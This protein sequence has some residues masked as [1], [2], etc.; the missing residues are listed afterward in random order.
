MHKWSVLVALFF[1]TSFLIVPQS[2]AAS[3]P[4][5]RISVYFSSQDR[6]L[7]EVLVALYREVQKGGYI[8]IITSSL[9]HP[10]LG[11][12][13][14]EARKRGVDVKLISDRRM[15]DTKRDE[16]AMYNLR[17]MGISIKVNQF[18]GA[19][20]LEASIVDDRYLV[21]GSYNY[22][23]TEIRS[24]LGVRVDEQ[25]LMVIPTGVD[26]LILQRYKDEFQRMWNDQKSYK[27][28][29]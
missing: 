24:P 21:V 1:I 14:A 20:Q 12:A 2:S 5:D 4:F 29:E 17:A 9:T 8:W 11:H 27:A 22:G 3:L 23:S 19:L 25:N 28:L 26:K 15:L 7:E 10:A 18:S 16:I 13:L 6:N